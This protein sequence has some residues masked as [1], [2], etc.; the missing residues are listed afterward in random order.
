VESLV[1]TLVRIVMKPMIDIRFGVH[2]SLPL[3]KDFPS[4]LHSHLSHRGE[5]TNI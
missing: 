2:Q 1:K 5:I 3:E 4:N